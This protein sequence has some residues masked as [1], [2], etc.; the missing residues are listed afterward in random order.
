MDMNNEKFEMIKDIG[1]G[2]FGVAKLMKDRYTNE[3]VAVKFIERGEKIDK[4]AS[5]QAAVLWLPMMAHSVVFSC[6]SPT[7]SPAL[8]SRKL[9]LSVSLRQGG[10][11]LQECAL[12]LVLHSADDTDPS[13]IS[14]TLGT[15][16]HPVYRW[17][18][19]LPAGMWRGS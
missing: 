16:L 13:C 6:C 2:N 3:L 7:N 15:L 4:C 1:S 8:S 10:W 19:G 9:R 5:H 18:G 11:N 14:K 12:R 17:L